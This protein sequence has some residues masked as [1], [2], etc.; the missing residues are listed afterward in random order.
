MRGHQTL[1][2]HL[3]AAGVAAALRSPTNADVDTQSDTLDG[4]RSSWRGKA[5][6]ILNSARRGE[7]I[8]LQTAPE[9]TCW[10]EVVS[11]TIATHR[12]EA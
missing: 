10:S 12:Q 11:Q 6:Q 5:L 2:T 9:R 7:K 8:T 1:V 4:Q 3:A